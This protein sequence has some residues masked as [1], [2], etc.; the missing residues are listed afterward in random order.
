MR[1]RALVWMFVMVA[2]TACGGGGGDDDGNSDGDGGGSN[3]DGGGGGGDG[4]G[5]PDAPPPLPVCVPSCSTAA[6]CGT[7]PAGSII[8]ANNYACDGGVCRW[9]GCLSTAECVATY[10]TQA[11]TCEAAFG[12]TVPTCWPTCTSATQCANPNSPLLGADNYAC[13]GGKCRWLGCNDTSECTA[14]NMSS[15][16]TCRKQSGMRNCFH[17]CTTPSDCATAS[18]PYDADNYDCVA[19]T[20]LWTGC[21]TTA[22]CMSVD[23]DWV[24]R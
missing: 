16:W 9:L 10:G 15:A 3:G 11:W 20:C 6:D 12:A 7:G 5:G 18:A 23:P 2:A 13:D 4:G 22:E 17:T 1:T 19:G 24:C 14:A 21:N 8:D